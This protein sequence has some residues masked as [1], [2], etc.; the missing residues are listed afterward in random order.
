MSEETPLWTPLHTVLLPPDCPGAEEDTAAS[1]S[2]GQGQDKP[3]PAWKPGPPD[4]PP[5]GGQ[6][7]QPSSHVSVLDGGLSPVSDAG[8]SFHSDPRG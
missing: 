8:T 7:H 5:G 6:V 4:I 2:R 1:G 3:A